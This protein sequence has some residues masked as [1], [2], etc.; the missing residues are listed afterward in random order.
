MSLDART[1]GRLSCEALQAE[2]RLSPKPGLVDAENCGA[3]SDMDL[4]LLLASATVLEPYFVLFAARGIAEAALPPEG[5]LNAIRAEGR[6]AEQAMLAATNGVNT[7]K[8]ALFLLGAL[9]YAAGHLAG[10]GGALAPSSVCQTAAKVCAGI[11]RELGA[12]AG[13]AFAKFSARGARGEA[14]D[15]FP[16]VLFALKEREKATAR[17]MTNHDAWLFALLK[18]IETLEDTNVLAR[19][20]EQTARE[21]KARASMIASRNPSGGEA[22][23]VDMRGLNQDCLRWHASP[24]GAADVLACA[25]FLQSVMEQNNQKW[26]DC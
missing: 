6:E 23:K 11:T 22:L 12:G 3:H 26:G 17:G 20:G 5:R 16:N 7:H 18:L 8:G 25:I 19:C 15:G 2:A 4:P 13:R 9:C 24:G 10:N 1:I 14:E 21:L